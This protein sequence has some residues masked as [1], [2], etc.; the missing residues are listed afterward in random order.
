MNINYN[1]NA[2]ANGHQNI[3]NKKKNA[4][5]QEEEDRQQKVTSTK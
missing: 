3:D 5:R 4:E 1:Q 2:S